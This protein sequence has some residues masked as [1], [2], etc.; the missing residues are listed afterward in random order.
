MGIVALVYSAGSPVFNSS[1]S[2]EMLRI[3]AESKVLRDAFAYVDL[4]RGH[5]PSIREDV[6][7]S[8][9]SNPASA[10]DRLVELAKTKL[11]TGFIPKPDVP[12]VTV[13]IRTDTQLF[14][15]LGQA[16]AHWAAGNQ[17]TSRFLLHQLPQGPFTGSALHL[18][19]LKPWREAIQGLTVGATEEARRNFRRASEVASQVGTK[20]ASA[21]QWTYIASFFH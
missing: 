8:M 9:V 11:V 19:A 12:N 3:L 17:E 20:T 10:E 7:S 21:V 6:R 5:G 2:T 18:M 16:W 4:A 15:Y 14:R 13:P 1:P